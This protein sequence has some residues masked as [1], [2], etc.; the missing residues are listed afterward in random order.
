MRVSCWAERKGR[1]RSEQQ[2]RQEKKDRV[3]YSGSSAS[4]RGS[5]IEPVYRTENHEAALL[6]AVN[7]TK[8]AFSLALDYSSRSSIVAATG[9]YFNTST[10]L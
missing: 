8:S 5:A 4:R 9:Y 7:T 10:G 1:R 3:Y 6:T 2:D